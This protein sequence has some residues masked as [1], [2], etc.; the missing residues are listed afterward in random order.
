MES[1]YTSIRKLVAQPMISPAW[2]IIAAFGAYFSVYGLR[3]PFTSATYIDLHILGFNAKSVFVIS[4]VFGYTISKFRGISLVSSI[5]SDR[6]IST[7]LALAVFSEAALVFFGMA[8]N[9][10]KPLCLFLNGLPIGMTFGLILRF[11][12]GR[13]TTELLTSGLCASFIL[14]DGITKT[15]GSRLLEEG[16]TPFWM[17]AAAGG[18]FLIPF[19]LFVWM[20]SII[21]VPGSLDISYRSERPAMSYQDR[22]DLFRRF[23]PGLSLVIAVYLLLTILRSLR[24]DFATEIW[25]GLG[26]RIQP[27]LFAYSEM[28]VAFTVL[29]I[30]ASLFVVKE[31]RRGFFLGLALSLA[32]FI[33]IF[34]ASAAAGQH[35]LSGFEFMVLTGIGLYL[36]YVAVH[37]SLFERW[38]ALTREKGN[39]GY[40]LYLADS[41]GYLGYVAV[42]LLQPVLKMRSNMFVSFLQLSA[43]F[44]IASVALLVIAWAYFARRARHYGRNKMETANEH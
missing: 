11:L 31:N 18:V 1:S 44:S 33:V 19:C 2:A 12:E 21:P 29:I 14:A 20:L 35:L 42:V 39:I 22:L 3:K 15:V 34:G 40:L 41:V 36:P 37:T 13:R 43:I 23:A 25:S 30:S 8:P 7:L 32:G 9:S 38:L 16:V 10:L 5:E 28:V 26:Y 17:P 27:S 4:Q 6:R 24:A